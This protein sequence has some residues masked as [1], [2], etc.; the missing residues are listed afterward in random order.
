MNMYIYLCVNTS[1]KFVRR[2]AHGLVINILP[3]VMRSKEIPITR[4]FAVPSAPIN[5][6]RSFARFREIPASGNA[7]I[8]FGT[9]R[10]P[11]D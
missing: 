6:Q 2:V 10:Y 3:A 5:S 7:Q 1:F 9:S 4:E 8:P 11:V